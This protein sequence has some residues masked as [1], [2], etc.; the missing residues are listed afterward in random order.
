MTRARFGCLL[1]AIAIIASGCSSSPGEA[2]EVQGALAI[3]VLGAS[4]LSADETEVEEIPTVAGAPLNPF[5]LQVGQCFNEGSWWDEERERRIEL[6]A[7]IDCSQPH[8]KEIYFAT[9]FPAPGG[10]PFPGDAAMAEWSTEVC[11]SAFEPFVGEAYEV[12]RY[13]ITFIHPTEAT[14]EHEVGRHRRVSCVVFDNNGEELIGSA[15]GSAS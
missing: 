14:F 3:D 1:I 11:Y 6:T 7:A 9:E 10:A 15:R 12:S 2:A 4:N 8:Q 5:D 13:E